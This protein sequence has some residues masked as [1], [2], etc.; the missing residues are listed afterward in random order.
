MADPVSSVAYARRP[1]TRCSVPS[2]RPPRCCC[3]PPP[4][5]I[6][7]IGTAAGV[8]ILVAGGRDQELVQFYAVAVFASFLGALT[9]AARLAWRDGRRT[10]FA[11]D[12]VG[13]A[14]IAFV[15]VLNLRRT[16]AVIALGAAALLSLALWRRWVARGR[17]TGVAR[18]TR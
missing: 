18:A 17:P 10:A 12:A 4:W 14:L 15:L 6:A 13:V 7:A 8:L 1:G 2:R 3:S 9:A 11:V 16:D 5:G